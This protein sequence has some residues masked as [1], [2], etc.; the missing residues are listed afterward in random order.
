MVQ[1]IVVVP[2]PIVIP[3]LI[4]NLLLIEL[5]RFCVYIMSSNN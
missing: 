2:V 4:E 5:K 1:I 3:D